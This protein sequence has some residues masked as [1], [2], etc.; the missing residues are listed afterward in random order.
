M[1]I[2]AKIKDKPK[3]PAGEDTNTNNLKNDEGLDNTDCHYTG[4]ELNKCREFV[5]YQKSIAW[6]MLKVPKQ[7]I[8]RKI[9]LECVIVDSLVIV[10]VPIRVILME[11]IPLEISMKKIGTL[12]RA[13]IT[14]KKLTYSFVKQDQEKV[15]EFIK[16]TKPLLENSPF[17]VLYE[18][19]WAFWVFFSNFFNFFEGVV[20]K[21]RVSL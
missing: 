8:K 12:K 17:L 11:L 5:H 13:N 14:Y 4:P 6:V 19:S 16:E 18:C 20:G 9:L 2:K 15:H 3:G 21:G 1:T 10:K 7:K